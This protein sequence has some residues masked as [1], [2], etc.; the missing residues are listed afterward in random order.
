MPADTGP[1]FEGE[2]CVIIRFCP[3]SDTRNKGQ[4]IAD[5]KHCLGDEIQHIGVILAFKEG[6]IE[7]ALERGSIRV[8]D[9]PSRNSFILCLAVA[10]RVGIAACAYAA[11]CRQNQAH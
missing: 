1:D 8:S 7:Q 5:S 4:V 9:S 3:G 10:Y 6:R 11:A 2:D